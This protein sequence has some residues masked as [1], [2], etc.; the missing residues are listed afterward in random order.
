MVL[1]SNGRFALGVDPV[2]RAPELRG[3]A[4]PGGLGLGLIIDAKS[5]CHP[6]PPAAAAPTNDEDVIAKLLGANVLGLTQ[7]AVELG[8]PR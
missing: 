7:R 8:A 5:P 1:G 4:A 3:V 2:G 6:A